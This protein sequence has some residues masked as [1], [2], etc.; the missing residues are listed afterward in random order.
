MRK[1]DDY[2]SGDVGAKKYVR[3]KN[4]CQ[5]YGMSQSKFEQ[6]AKEAGA[7]RKIDK[8]VLVNCQDL[9]EYIESFKV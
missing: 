7:I 5:L 8:L 3:Y 2:H 6:L 9:D 4:G 1:E